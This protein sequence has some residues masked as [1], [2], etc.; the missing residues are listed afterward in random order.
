MGES[1]KE[2]EHEGEQ[3]LG[4][5]GLLHLADEQM[6]TSNGPVAVRDFLDVCGDHARPY[7]EGF[8]KMDPSDPDYGST[9]DLL[10][11]VVGQYISDPDAGQS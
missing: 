10:R 8:R 9:R 6:Q 1:L 7:F 3:F 2:P 5:L 11:D 4:L